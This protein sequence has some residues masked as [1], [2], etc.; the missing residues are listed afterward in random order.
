MKMMCFCWS[1]QRSTYL[2]REN[3]GNKDSKSWIYTWDLRFVICLFWLGSETTLQV[4][5]LHKIFMLC[6]N[7]EDEFWKNS[8]LNLAIMF[9]PH[10]YES[11]LRERCKELPESVVNLIASFLSVEPEKRMT[12]TSALQS[13][14]TFMN[15][16]SSLNSIPKIS[17]LALMF[18]SSSVLSFETLRLWSNKLANV[19]TQQGDRCEISRGSKQVSLL[20]YL[21]T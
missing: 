20:L 2:K 12:A 11:S 6:G 10:D 4:E 13:E 9:K 1:F 17:Y 15:S 14:V 8:S 18:C 3:K 19:P 21:L 16:S 7:P 5:Q